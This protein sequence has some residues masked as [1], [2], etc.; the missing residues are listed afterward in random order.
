MT[1]NSISDNCNLTYKHYLNQPMHMCERKINLNI[2]EN[3]EL[4]TVLDRKK[5]IL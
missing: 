2:A 5:T 3:P 4:I 1:I